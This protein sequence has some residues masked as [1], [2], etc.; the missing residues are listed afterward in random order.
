[1]QIILNKRCKIEGEI[2][3]KGT[4]L[5]LLGV[6]FGEEDSKYYFYTVKGKI[7]INDA[8]IAPETEQE[9]G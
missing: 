6:E 9:K 1:M 4:K 7:N 2:I 5:K 3:P 8:K